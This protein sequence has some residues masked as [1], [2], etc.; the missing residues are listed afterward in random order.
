MDNR[1]NGRDKRKRPKVNGRY[2]VVLPAYNNE[3]TIGELVKQIRA[4]QFDTVV[5][6]DGSTDG[7][8]QRATDAGAIVISQLTNHGKGSALK[9]GFQYALENDYDGVVTIDADGQH[10]PKDIG[11]ILVSGERQH[12]GIVLGNRMGDVESMPSSRIWTNR[13]LSFII[14]KITGQE[15]PDSQCGLKMVRKEVLNAVQLKGDRYELE[16]ELLIKASAKKWKIISVPIKTIY[17]GEE[18]SNIKPV[19]DTL[20]MIGVLLSCRFS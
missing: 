11:K 10:D 7:T 20:R 19:R 12:A 9:L 17:T 16:T 5:V 15:I 18:V 4:Q 14:S 13:K 3:P 6:N 2:C 8:A 1:S